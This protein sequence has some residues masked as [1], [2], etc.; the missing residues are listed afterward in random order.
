MNRL[1]IIVALFFVSCSGGDNQF[2][3]CMNAGEELNNYSSELLS[4]GVENVNEREMNK[5]RS[6]KDSL[7][8]P[9]ELM[10]GD[11]LSALKESC[12]LAD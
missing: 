2:C 5:L 3:E 9:Y 10:G 8:S 7:C 4:N 11:D 12:G 1:I 6:K